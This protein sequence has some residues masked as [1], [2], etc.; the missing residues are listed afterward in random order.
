MRRSRWRP[1]KDIGWRGE[2]NRLTKCLRKITI[3]NYLDII[4]SYI[5]C[6][7]LLLAL[8]SMDT[9]FNVKIMLCE[10]VNAMYILRIYL[11]RT[12]YYF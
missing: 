4:T 1:F 3:L 6:M 11:A 5:I 12:K 2:N 7:V 8:P 10:L 9:W